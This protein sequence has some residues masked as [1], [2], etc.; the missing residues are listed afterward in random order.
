MAYLSFKHGSGERVVGDRTFT[1]MNEEEL[2]PLLVSSGLTT[3][4]L[5]ITADV[6]RNR[7]AERWLNALATV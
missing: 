4:D 3:V 2:L 5:W 7:S 1:D 6:R